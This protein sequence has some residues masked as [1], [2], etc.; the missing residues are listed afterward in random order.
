MPVPLSFNGR[1]QPRHSVC[2]HHVVLQGFPLENYFK[3]KYC[4]SPIL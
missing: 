3:R 4:K 1:L 2:N